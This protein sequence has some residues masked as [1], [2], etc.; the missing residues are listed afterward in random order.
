MMKLDQM[1]KVTVSPN[2]GTST[3]EQIACTSDAAT[4]DPGPPLSNTSVHVALVPVWD[5]LCLDPDVLQLAIRNRGD[6]KFK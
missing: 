4:P 2:P 3:E 5:V 6:R 1:K